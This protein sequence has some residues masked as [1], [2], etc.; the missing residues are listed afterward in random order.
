MFRERAFLESAPASEGC[1]LPCICNTTS[2]LLEEEASAR[3][4]GKKTDG[5]VGLS[6]IGFKAKRQAAVGRLRPGSRSAP[7]GIL[8]QL[9]W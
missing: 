4:A 5:R 3:T 1:K 9:G 7:E 8:N 6:L 2:L